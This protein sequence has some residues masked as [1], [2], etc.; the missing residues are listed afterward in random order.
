MNDQETNRLSSIVNG[1]FNYIP[2]AL[3][4]LMPV[5]FLSTT[6][7]FY[8]FNKLT[9]LTVATMLLVLA[10][11]Y[12]IIETKKMVITKSVIDLPFLLF[13]AAVVLSTIFSINKTTSIFG[14]QGRWFPS[15]FGVLVLFVFYYLVSGN[16]ND[17]KSIRTALYALVAGIS[18]S[19][20]IAILSYYNIYIGSANYFRASTFNLNGS[21]TTTV[22]IA[23]LSAVLALAMLMYEENMQKK[24]LLLVSVVVNYFFV[25]LVSII[26]GWV[27]LGVGVVGIVFF[28][29]YKKIMEN[30][31]FLTMAA[32]TLAAV[33]LVVF[34][35]T[36]RDLVT[37]PGYPKELTLPVKESWVVA[38]QTVQDYPTLATGPSTFSINFPRYRPL[39][40]NT[41]NL[42]NVRFDKAYNE[43]FN[44]LAT[45][46]IVGL[47]AALYL[48]YKGLK[49]VFSSLKT[50]DEDGL[51]KILGI[52]VLSMAA[53]YLVTYATVLSAFLIV[54]LMAMM[55]A[56]LAMNR[57]EMAENVALGL[58]SI[59][60]VTTI[61]EEGVIKKEYLHF[62][63]AL[64]LIAAVVYAG[65][66]WTKVYAAE[67]YLRTSIV[68]ANNNEGAKTFEYQSK[69]I[70]T[71]PR[72]DTYHNI[73]AQTNLALANSIASKDQLTDTDRQTIQQLIAQSI[74]NARL[75]TEVLDPLNVDNWVTRGTIYRAI[76]P[77]AQNA[78]Q[79]AIASYNTAV[80]LSPTDP[81]LR[82]DLGGIYYAN[83]DYL[84]A[85][86]FYR[87][88]ILLKQDYANAHFNFAQSLIKL[89][90]Y[91]N[92][93]RA[94]EITKTLVDP[95]S[96]DYKLVQ[97]QLDNLPATTEPSNLP[98]VEQIEGSSPQQGQQA[99]Q[100]AKQEPLT[101]VGAEES[102]NAQNLDQQ[103][104]PTQEQNQQPQDQQ[105]TQTNT[106]STGNTQGGNTGS[107]Q[108]P[109]QQ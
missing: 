88:A 4:F 101:T 41:G 30:T 5:F 98:T 56:N 37:N 36:T 34:L 85:A 68:A 48:V 43:V 51:S 23:A 19:S 44:T 12:R 35:P 72:R 58:S 31:V 47:V 107:N 9:L 69:A 28:V 40:L 3:A 79:W 62:I 32:G 83:G 99:E 50:H 94:L 73:F 33:T 108:Q 70:N 38:S 86:N 103:V 97:Q 55:V 65:Y 16:L 93:K 17:R 39:S 45:I 11:T 6:S 52:G 105:Q 71:N 1:L 10:W 42:W 59:A 67:Y 49:L 96:N 15:L 89:Q 14:S 64:P 29:S 63:F 109:A 8:E 87:Q 74:R 7:E 91:A 18:F 60:P 53:V 57:S 21:V 95:D 75:S 13:I 82:L 24:A 100:P 54:F 22:V 26:P 20:I 25:A 2:V 76:S 90:D 77:I 27:V 66:V 81:R 102:T 80:Q 84:T 92:A 78:S 46:G 106:N 104:L 61:G